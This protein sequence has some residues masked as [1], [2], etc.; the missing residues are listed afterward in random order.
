[1]VA[2]VPIPVS[3]LVL[4]PPGQQNVLGHPAGDVSWGT[5][6][7]LQGWTQRKRYLP[8]QSHGLGRW[9][10]EVGSHPSLRLGCGGRRDSREHRILL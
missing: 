3:S 2:G 1:M 9:V 7:G 10:S 4:Q 5:G 6:Q 8:E